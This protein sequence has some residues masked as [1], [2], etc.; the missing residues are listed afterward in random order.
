MHSKGFKVH[1][2]SENRG[3]VQKPLFCTSSSDAPDLRSH[4]PPQS[5]HLLQ[6]SR[7]LCLSVEGRN[8]SEATRPSQGRVR[9]QEASECAI[10]IGFPTIRAL[11]LECICWQMRQ[12]CKHPR[13]PML[14]KQHLKFILQEW[15]LD[16]ELLH[17]KC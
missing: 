5:Y 17:D 6:S 8:E 9:I 7:L 11:H 13:C 10:L 4:P 15:R 16:Q 2:S 14:Y 1:L 12:V 3:A